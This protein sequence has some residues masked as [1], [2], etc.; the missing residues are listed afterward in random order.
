MGHC[1]YEHQAG[2]SVTCV[3]WIGVLIVCAVVVAIVVV[4]VA[5]S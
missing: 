5:S 2:A 1:E 3:F 4:L